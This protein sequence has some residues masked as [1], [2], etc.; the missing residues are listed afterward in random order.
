MNYCSPNKKYDSLNVENIKKKNISKSLID[1]D[2]DND[3]DNFTCFSLQ[4]LIEIA[5]A[6]NNYIKKNGKMCKKIDNKIVCALKTP[7]NISKKIQNNNGNAKKEL[8]NSI[9]KRLYKLC[10]KNDYKWIDLNFINLISDDLLKESVK[11]FTFKPKMTK[12]DI[13][14]LTSN[15][16]NEILQQYTFDNNNKFLFIGAQPSD[17]SKIKKIDYNKIKKVEN[18]GIV[19]N[20]DTHKQPGSHWIAVYIDNQNKIIDYFDSLG[21]KINKN[22]QDFIN[23]FLDYEYKYNINN[24]KHQKGGSQCGIYSVFYIIKRL[25]GMSFNQINKYFL[26]LN[27]SDTFMR[28]YRKVLFRPRN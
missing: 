19:F 23:N 20:L 5:K 11:Y 17:Y 25:S 8:Y 6:F 1:N 9:S 15:D 13:T 21:N 3:N 14:W 28:E 27:N 16:I 22:I 7:I 18:I 24:I 12:T 4:E 10:G 2:N 26:N